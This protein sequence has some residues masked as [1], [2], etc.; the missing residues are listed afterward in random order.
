MDEPGVAARREGSNNEIP[1]ADPDAT[2]AQRD[3]D[4]KRAIAAA[5]RIGASA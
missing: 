4:A 1:H 2:D 5:V 3:L